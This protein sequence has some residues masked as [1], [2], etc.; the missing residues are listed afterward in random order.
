MTKGIKGFQLGHKHSSETKEKIGLANRGIWTKFYCNYCKVK[1]E[2]QQSHYKRSKKHF[3]SMRCYANYRMEFMKPEEQPTWKGGITQ[4]TQRGR[5][6]KKYKI[7]QQMVFER[8]NFACVVCKSKEKIEA[9]HIKSWAKYPK[10]RYNVD[11][12]E[13]RCI[14]HHDRN[15][16]NPELLGGPK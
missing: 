3:C 4:E 1:S 14:K 2:E 6:N 8:D 7:W 9:H 13:T 16:K 12:G 15:K 11:N 5:G 10:L